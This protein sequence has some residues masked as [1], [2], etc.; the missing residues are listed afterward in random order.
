LQED[1]EVTQSE[2]DETHWRNGMTCLYGGERRRVVAA[3]FE[4]RLLGLQCG[5]DEDATDYVRCENVS[6]VESPEDGYEAGNPAVLVEV[7]SVE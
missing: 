3:L 5:D 7:F 1:G 2:F 6:D 4:E